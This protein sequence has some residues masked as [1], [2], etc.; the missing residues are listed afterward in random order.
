MKVFIY[1]DFTYVDFTYCVL[2]ITTTTTIPPAT[3]YITSETL[4]HDYI[5]FHES[6]NY[7]P[8]PNQLQFLIGKITGPFILHNINF[9]HM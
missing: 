4:L 2:T 3:N 1:F 6:Q 9:E 5:I 7:S 8:F